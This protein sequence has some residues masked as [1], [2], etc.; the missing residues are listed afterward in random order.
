MKLYATLENENG[1]RVS[2]GANDKITIGLNRSNK[3]IATIDYDGKTI[4]IWYEGYH[5]W[6]TELQGVNQKSKIDENDIYKMYQE[7]NQ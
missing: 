1:A 3:N 6:C 2:K 7:N 4:K 5:Y